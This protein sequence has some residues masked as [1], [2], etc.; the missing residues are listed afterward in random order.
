MGVGMGIGI[1]GMTGGIIMDE[2]EGMEGTGGMGTSMFPVEGT[3]IT[4]NYPMMHRLPCQNVPEKT[5]FQTNH[6][7]ALRAKIAS[8]LTRSIKYG[9]GLIH[10][11]RKTQVWIHT[12]G[13]MR[14]P[15]GNSEWTRKSSSSY[16]GGTLPSPVVGSYGPT[17]GKTAKLHSSGSELVMSPKMILMSVQ[18]IAVEHC[19]T[20]VLER[21]M[22]AEGTYRFVWPGSLHPFRQVHRGGAHL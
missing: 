16:S 13:T 8:N 6:S 18:S 15:R 4:D 14:A 10:V 22:M 12:S 19:W 20:R 21:M 7:C 11:S 3:G 9:S 2:M 1:G 17:V 5:E